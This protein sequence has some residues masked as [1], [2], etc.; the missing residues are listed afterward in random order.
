MTDLSA[1]G[2]EVGRKLENLQLD[3]ME[4]LFD[5]SFNPRENEPKPAAVAVADNQLS[6]YEPTEAD[7]QQA[8][9]ALDCRLS[10]MREGFQRGL[11][12]GEGD[13]QLQMGDTFDESSA[14]A[15]KSVK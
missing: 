5:D 6:N 4:D 10:E 13:F 11:S 7:L 9:N 12:F 3:R 2:P 8:I 1:S 14:A 15:A